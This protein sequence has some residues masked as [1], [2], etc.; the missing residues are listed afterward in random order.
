MG[1]CDAAEVER[2][3]SRK[4]KSPLKPQE[5]RSKKEDQFISASLVSPRRLLN[6]PRI[7]ASDAPRGLAV[8]GLTAKAILMIPRKKGRC[9]ERAEVTERVFFK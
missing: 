8:R 9:G 7:P 5:E 6:S 4:S 2:G 3:G 1:V